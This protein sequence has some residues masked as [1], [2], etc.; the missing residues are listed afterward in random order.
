LSGAAAA[1][2]TA[3]SMI[4]CGQKANSEQWNVSPSVI[5]DQCCLVQTRATSTVHEGEERQC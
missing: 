1:D 4:W 2:T 3:G 5:V